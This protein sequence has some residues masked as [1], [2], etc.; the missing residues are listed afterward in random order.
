MDFIT[1]AS[2]VV[3]T[4]YNRTVRLACCLMSFYAIRGRCQHYF[5]MMRYE[6]LVQRNPGIPSITIG[7]FD[8]NDF[9][10][11]GHIGSSTFFTTEMWA[12]GHKK[13]ALVGILI[14]THE[15]IFMTLSR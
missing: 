4:R 11:S 6:N 12:L 3:W 15:W 13:M 5:F 14:V 2:L 10:F 9:Y 7:Y 8:L 1:I